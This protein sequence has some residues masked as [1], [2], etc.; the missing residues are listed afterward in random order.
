MK[1]RRWLAGEVCRLTSA[2]VC[3]EMGVDPSTQRLASMEFH[4][5]L[6]RE[7]FHAARVD[8]TVL[9]CAVGNGKPACLR[10]SASLRRTIPF[11]Q[12][13]EAA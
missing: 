9:A 13:A 12:L 11:T 3:Y 1:A 7:R 10:R 6:I 2:L 8:P 5:F 4:R